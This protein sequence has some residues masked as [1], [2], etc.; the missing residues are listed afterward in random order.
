MMQM[1]KKRQEAVEEQFEEQLQELKKSTERNLLASVRDISEEH[2]RLNTTLVELHSVVDENLAHQHKA[3]EADKIER[4]QLQKLVE[5]RVGELRLAVD[6]LSLRAEKSESQAQEAVALARKA[7]MGREADRKKL[8]AALSESSKRGESIVDCK[9]KVEELGHELRVDMHTRQKQ[10]DSLE[11]STEALKEKGERERSKITRDL[12]KFENLMH[13]KL[14]KF[15]AAQK[16]HGDEVQATQ[17]LASNY[18]SDLETKLKDLETKLKVAGHK[19][20]IEMLEKRLS[21]LTSTISTKI[22]VKVSEAMQSQASRTSAS[23]DQRME[24]LYK[25]MRE[26]TG[27]LKEQLSTLDSRVTGAVDKF[28][29][30]NHLSGDVSSNVEL[31]LQAMK[32]EIQ[33]SKEEVKRKISLSR[34][35]AEAEVKRVVGE[36]T[37]KF[38]KSS[39]ETRR[40]IT[41]IEEKMKSMHQLFST[42]TE[43]LGTDRK[44]L[45]YCSSMIFEY[46]KHILKDSEVRDLLHDMTAK[47]CSRVASLETKSGMPIQDET[48]N[49]SNLANQKK[50]LDTFNRMLSENI[51]SQMRLGPLMSTPDFRPSSTPIFTSTLD[52]NM[53][54]FRAT[55]DLEGK[56]DA[57]SWIRSKIAAD[58]AL[59]NGPDSSTGYP[60]KYSSYAA[61]ETS[62]MATE[63]GE[64]KQ[65]TATYEKEERK[66]K[67]AHDGESA[68]DL[69]KEDNNKKKPPPSPPQ[70]LATSSPSS[71]KAADESQSETNEH[72]RAVAVVSSGSSEMKGGQIASISVPQFQTDS[73]PSTARASGSSFQIPDDDET[74]HGQKNQADGGAK[75]LEKSPSPADALSGGKKQSEEIVETKDEFATQLPGRE[76]NKTE[77]GGGHQPAPANAQLSQL[78]GA[79][80]DWDEDEDEDAGGDEETKKN[81]PNSAGEK[82]GTTRLH[83]PIVGGDENKAVEDDV[84][85]ENKGSLDG[86]G[87]AG[88]TIPIES[89]DAGDQ[90]GS[91][92]SDDDGELF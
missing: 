55:V 22:D 67:I 63:Y 5:E 78:E 59:P 37:T 60:H 85:A 15:D 39:V 61:E 40:R 51:K 87:K 20:G 45:E 31:K 68:T 64:K 27:T 36:Q 12:Q 18:N 35:D 21:S 42:I 28:A 17:R 53:T 7:E 46:G 3:Q 9:R 38:D 14:T 58:E 77:D 19:Q 73:P 91:W 25:S 79:E 48:F 32:N 57:E 86:E 47:L 54:P 76:N 24:S 34:L 4:E 92:D 49:L 43:E 62:L 26:T 50:E 81:T 80:S 30:G 13:S 1:Q 69:K 90:S 75:N 74:K 2:V 66:A 70:K 89:K 88:V 82:T 52:N 71:N 56:T 29:T 83:L 41:G 8:E 84:A 33:A 65:D 44:R 6:K 11:R 72:L 16:S 10:L 23:I